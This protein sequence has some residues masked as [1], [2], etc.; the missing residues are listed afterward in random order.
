VDN[1]DIDTEFAAD[2]YHSDL[3]FPEELNDVQSKDPAD[4]LRD[5]SQSSIPET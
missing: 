2:C 5:I 4:S 3:L 1:I